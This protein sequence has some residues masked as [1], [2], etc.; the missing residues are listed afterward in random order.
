MNGFP[1]WTLRPAGDPVG[2]P[3]VGARSSPADRVR[4]RRPHTIVKFGAEPISREPVF[5]GTTG[6]RFP[7]MVG[8]TPVQVWT[9]AS[10]PCMPPDHLRGEAEFS[11]GP[12]ARTSPPMLTPAPPDPHPS[13]GTPGAH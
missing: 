1:P 6:D 9:F 11:A 5:S 7:Y 12:Q 10:R 4:C 3:T 13:A 8:G 2:S